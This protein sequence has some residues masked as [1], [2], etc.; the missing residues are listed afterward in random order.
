MSPEEWRPV[1]GY[2]GIYEVSDR[3]RIRRVGRTRGARVGRIM[4]TKPGWGGYPYLIL[5]RG[6]TKRGH[7]VHAVVAEAFH[8]PRP[9]GYEVNHRDSNRLNPAAAN[10]EWVTRAENVAHMRRAGRANDAIGER[11]SRARLTE[12]DV[13][14]IR[15]STEGLRLLGRRYGVHHT[16]IRDIRLRLT[17][18]HV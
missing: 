7:F 3:G 10:L 1:L 16:T 12:A 5:S 17:W 8:G 15:A 4:R 18:R 14:A 9:D 6:N 11:A 2:E 13:A